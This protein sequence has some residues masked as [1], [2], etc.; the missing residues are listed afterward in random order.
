MLSAASSTAGLSSAP[1]VPGTAYPT[2]PE[3]YEL[4]AE[5]GKGAFATVYLAY[6][7]KSE[8]HVAIKVLDLEELDTSWEEIRKEI[9]V[10]GL[11]NHPNVVRCLCSFVVDREIWLV[12]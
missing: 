10:M 9:A 1:S 6:C 3:A 12:M 11:L 2:N 8:E 5:L 4:K 7:K